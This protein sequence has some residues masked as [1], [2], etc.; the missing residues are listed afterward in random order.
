[1]FVLDRFVYVDDRAVIGRMKIVFVAWI[2]SS[3][4]N[5]GS[6]WECMIDSFREK[7]E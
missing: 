3:G 5:G 7:A 4:G 2:P 1:M 6:R